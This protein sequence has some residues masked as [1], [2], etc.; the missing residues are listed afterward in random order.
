MEVKTECLIFLGRV[1]QIRA[2]DLLQTSGHGCVMRAK[3]CQC[4]K[5]LS[6]SLPPDMNDCLDFKIN[7]LD[8]T[9]NLNCQKINGVV[10]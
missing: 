5:R 10:N 7:P 4:S 2:I 6:A 3:M 8:Y 9:E 1:F